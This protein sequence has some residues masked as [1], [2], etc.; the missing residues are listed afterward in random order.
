M[1]NTGNIH[2]RAGRAAGRRL[3][4]L[5]V[6]MERDASQNTLVIITGFLVGLFTGSIAAALKLL[7]SMVN[8]LCLLGIDTDVPN[9]PILLYPLAGVAIT[10]LF[11]R[12]VVGQQC[13]R[14]TYLIR[15]HID[16]GDSRISPFMMFDPMIGC[17][18]TIGMGASGG[19]EG[20]VA[21]C[22]SAVGSNVARA[23]RLTP[24]WDRLMMAIG[25]GAGIAAIFKAPMGGVLF[26]L[27]VLQ[28]EFTTIPMIALVLACILAS[29]TASLF[30]NFTLDID[31]YQSMRIDVSLMGW[32]AL[33]GVLCGLYCIYFNYTKNRTAGCFLG[34]RNRVWAALGSGALLSV[35]AFVFPA[36][37]GTG[38][39]VV[40]DL[41]NGRSAEFLAGGLFTGHSGEWG[42]VVFAA[43]GMLL[44]KGALVGAAYSGGGISGDFVP[45]LFAG[46][47]L[48]FLFGQGMNTVFGMHM[49]VWYF[50]LMGMAA[51][52]AGTV[53]APLM[54]IFILCET[55]D[56]S[57]YLVAYL[58]AVALC[59][60]TVKV[61]TPK[62]W[63][64][65]TGHDDMMMIRMWKKTPEIK[66]SGRRP[67]DRN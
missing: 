28:M 36:L 2:Q 14:G 63:Y 11:Q 65:E 48:G 20:P 53:H 51:V 19:T 18:V 23:L 49:P 24:S 44:L 26:A 15:R 43:M 33:L 45:T 13:S 57:G 3:R 6:V 29:S 66:I 7:V 64:A 50:C 39:D 8:E 12:Y 21:L 22:G 31:F 52:M 17:S 59:Y 32:V 67:R 38:M 4:R 5:R 55:T 46:C 54:A 60:A 40:E 58:V 30:S 25:A 62:S 1:K 9:W 37:F 27:E 56:T 41:I 61:V 47:V 16:S 10:A 35:S 42:W 34:M